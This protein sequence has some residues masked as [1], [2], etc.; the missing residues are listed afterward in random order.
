VRLPD[1][2]K[3]IDMNVKNPPSEECGRSQR[4]FDLLL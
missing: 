2:F 1:M 3:I 4:I